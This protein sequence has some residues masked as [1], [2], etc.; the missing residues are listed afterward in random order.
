LLTSIREKKTI[1]DEIKADLKQVVQDF[2]ASWRKESAPPTL[3][4]AA[5]TQAAAPSAIA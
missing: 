2:K 1:T 3:G 4:T 5:V